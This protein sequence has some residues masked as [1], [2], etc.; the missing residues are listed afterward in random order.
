MIRYTIVDSVTKVTKEWTRQRRAEMRDSSRA[1]R[2][3]DAFRRRQRFSV[4]DA[5][6]Q[7]MADAYFKASSGKTLPAHARQIMYAGR[8]EI[9]RLTGK[10]LK[11]KYFTQTLLPNYL[12]ENPDTTADWDVVFDARGHFHE[13]HTGRTV[14]LG[15]LDVRHYLKSVQVPEKPPFVDLGFRQLFPTSGPEHRYQAILFIEKEGFLP[16]FRAADL[17]ERFDIAI[18][19]TKGLSVTAS[20][21]LVDRLC[22]QHGIPL[23]VLH[24]FDKSGFSILGTL[25]RDTRRYAFEYE[26]DVI[27]L[28]LRLEDVETYDLESEE[29]KFKKGKGQTRDPRDN[30][31]LNGAQERELDFLVSDGDEDDGFTGRRVELNA[32]TS[33]DLIAWIEGKLIERG[34]KKLVPEPAVVAEAYRRQLAARFFEHRS[35]DLVAKAK[36]F[37][38]GVSVPPSFAAAVEAALAKSPHL[39]WDEAIARMATKYFEDCQR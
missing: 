1:L 27:D 12:I 25:I 38:G 2:R 6:W 4:L 29:V 5:A 8:A 34:I 21:L 16:L 23:F 32:F 37:A 17:A 24:D 19:S 26:F 14:P 31:R 7:V 33:G 9:Q 30:L 10:F 39:S 15:T 22:G 28:G 36:D 20:R 13:P 3:A 11:D 18:M 35:Q